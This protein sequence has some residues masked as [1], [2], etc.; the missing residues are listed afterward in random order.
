MKKK[1]LAALLAVAM[2]ATMF[3]GC[4]KKEEKVINVM[5]F[6]D[7]IPNMIQKYLDMTKSDYKLNTTIVA[8]T[9]QQY[10]PAL[11]EMLKGDNAPD[12]YGLEA[13]FVLKYTQGDAAGFAA[14]YDDLGIDTTK[15]IADAKIATYAAEVGTRPADGKVVALPYQATGGCFIYRRSIAKDTWGTDDPKT[16]SEK[17][18]GGS[19]SWDQFW[20]AAEDLKAKGYGIISGDGDIWHAI[21]NS[22]DSAWIVD[23]KLNIDPKREAL[24]DVSKK[25][26]DNDYHNETQDW[27]DGWFADMKGEGPKQIFGFFGPAW[28]INYTMGDNCGGKTKGEGTFGDWAVTNSPVGF[29]WGG[30]YVASAKSAVDKMNDEKKALVADIIEWITLDTDENSLQYKWANGLMVD[31]E[32]GTK[33]TVASAVVME[34]SNGEVAFLDGQNMFE[35]F[36]P[37][38]DYATGAN[39]TQHDEA[40]NGCWREAVRAYVAGDVTREGAIEKFRADVK[41]KVGIE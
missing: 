1:L 36:V 24:L 32:V 41:S 3:A 16:I 10:Q 30:T 12:L 5:S 29:C 17:I 4:G 6:T 35:Y 13:A 15:R 26:K 25:L 34:K 2:V 9:D 27:Q 8:T 23:G 39:M 22:S 18:G 37:A 40:I 11:D 21:E 14:T 28:L 38:G 19:Q 20:V 7:E 31:G 33:D